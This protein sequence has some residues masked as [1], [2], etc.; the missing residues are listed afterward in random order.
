MSNQIA[1]VTRRDHRPRVRVVGQDVRILAMGYEGARVDLPSLKKWNPGAGSADADILRDLV[2][3]RGRTRDLSRNNPLASGAISTVVENAVG[4]GLAVQS[5][6]DREYLGLSE[7]EAAEWQRNVE[8]LF[9]ACADNLDIERTSNFLGLQDL[10][11]RSTLDSGDLFTIRRYKPYPGD[12]IGLKLQLIEAD[13]VC[14]PHHMPDQRDLAGGVERDANGAPVAY[15]VLESH[16]GD[17]YT[18]AQLQEWKRIPAFDRFGRRQVLHHYRKR[19]VGATRGVPYFAPVIEHILQ[20]GRYTKAEVEAA[21]INSFFTVLTKSNAPEGL[22]SLETVE[23]NPAT[24]RE[25]ELELASG[26]IADLAPGEDVV[27]ADPKRPNVNFGAFSEA[28]LKQVAVGLE[29]PYEVLMKHF[30]S[31]YSAARAALLDAWKFFLSWRVWLRDTFCQP[32]YEMV[33]SELVARGYIEAPG[34]F[35]DPLA[36]TAWLN[37]EWVGDAPGQIDPLKEA[38]AMETRLA[39]HV[40]TLKEETSAFSGKDWQRNLEQRRRELAAQQEAG[41]ATGPS[42]EL[43][44]ETDHMLQ[45]EETNDE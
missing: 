41:M 22:G 20:L 24:D 36:R 39:L 12:I 42:D 7:E 26:T 45:R 10:V 35:T 5:Q 1:V 40:T 14:N 4:T 2:T 32:V 3:L 33:V 31:S 6:I 38:K 29:M 16:P 18:W 27:F 37:T 23:E 43:R 17:T 34:F 30:N 19:R 21:V 44:E 11:L 25:T 15:H 9:W 13:R 28:I 8:R